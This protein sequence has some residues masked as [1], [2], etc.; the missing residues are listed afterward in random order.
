M[1]VSV[2]YQVPW[3]S[4]IFFVGQSLFEADFVVYQLFAFP[5]RVTVSQT[6]DQK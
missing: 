1:V 6:K 4:K 2:A 5:K 3:R